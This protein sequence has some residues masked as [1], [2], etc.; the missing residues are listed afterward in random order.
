MLLSFSMRANTNL[1]VYC[2]ERKRK[3]NNTSYLQTN[4]PKATEIL[5]YAVKQN[6]KH[7]SHVSIVGL[8]SVAL[9]STSSRLDELRRVF[10]YPASERLRRKNA[11]PCQLIIALATRHTPLERVF[12]ILHYSATTFIGYELER[13]NF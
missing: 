2:T 4:H 13:A 6:Q 1:R 10:V 5:L 7:R 12:K 9:M 3:H 8:H 11:F